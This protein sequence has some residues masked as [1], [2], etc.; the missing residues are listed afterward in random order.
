MEVPGSKPAI[1]YINHER[2]RGGATVHRDEFVRAVRAT[3]ANFTPLLH[4]E[5]EGAAGVRAGRWQRFKGWLY[6]SW[7]DLALLFMIARHTPR[8]A[9][10]LLR[11]KPD[12]LLVNYSFHISS[13]L[14]ARALSV[15]VV[16]QIHCAYYLHARYENVCLRFP[17]FWRWMERRAIN[18]AS[19]VVVVSNTLKDYYQE[20]GFPKAKVS[21]VPNG[22]DHSQ[23]NATVSSD[24]IRGRLGLQGSLVIGFVGALVPWT[25]VDWFLE[26]LHRLGPALENVAVLIIGSG[27]L[28]PR[29]R[30]IVAKS[31]LEERVRFAGFVPHAEIPGYMASFDVAVAP[32]RKVEL[33]YN[34]PMKIHEY[35]AMGKPVLAP[36]MGQNGELIQHGENGLLYEPDDAEGMLAHLRHLI[37]DANLRARLGQAARVRS[38]ETVWSWERNAAA[39]LEVCCAAASHRLDGTK[40]PRAVS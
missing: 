8:E 13:I 24:A 18:L 29:L 5:V 10:A 33:F 38:H 40:T 22:V 34:S 3:G 30:Q 11:T 28:E 35:L 20:L 4:S 31:G 15:P 39:I 26:A 21:V 6:D 19:A 12:V 32:Y 17:S 16:L 36:R 37:Q 7:T 14:L 9:L 27:G 25:G 1:L 2:W 23:F